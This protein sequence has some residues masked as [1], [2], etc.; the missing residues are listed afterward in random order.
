MLYTGKVMKTIKMFLSI[1]TF[2]LVCSCASEPAPLEGSKGVVFPH[3]AE[4]CAAQPELPWCNN[5][6]TP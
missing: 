1:F 4:Q 2:V 5:E 3:V 6:P